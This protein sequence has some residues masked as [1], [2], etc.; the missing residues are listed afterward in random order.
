MITRLKIVNFQEYI[1][2]QARFQKFFL[3]FNFS[4][5]GGGA[6]QKIAEKMKFSTKKVT[7]YS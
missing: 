4:G 5:G 3:L 6:A 7:K 1:E 2:N